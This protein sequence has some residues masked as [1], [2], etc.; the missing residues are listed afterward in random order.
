[1]VKLGNKHII[2][3]IVAIVVIADV[4]FTVFG[5]NTFAATA[6]NNTIKAD[7]IKDCSSTPWVVGMQLGFFKN[8]SINF[9]DVGSIS[10]QN[11]PAALAAGQINVFDGHPN[12]I[13]DLLQAGVKVNATV[14]GGSEPSVQNN[15]TIDEDHMHYDVLSTSPYQNISDIKTALANGTKIKVAV[16]ATGT[17]ADLEF[18]NWL[19]ENG[20][21]MSTINNQIQYVVLVDPDQVQAMKEGQIDISSLH[22]PFYKEAETEGGVNTLVTSYQAF[23][24]AA[25]MSLLV[26]TDQYIK[27]YPGTVRDFTNAYKDSERWI[28]NNREQAGNITAAYIGLPYTSNVHYYS[29]SGAFD[30]TSIGYLQDWINAM[31]QQGD[32]PAGKYT[33]QDLYTTEFQDTWQP[34]LPDN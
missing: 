18:N 14:V 24:P 28:Q 31:V 23:G 8:A 29:E 16:V 20:V 17:C 1:M 6:Q 26:F 3:S 5:T 32:I 30:N 21:N 33:P 9:I 10:E 34:N 25:G 15:S 13:I 19:L 22:P 4:I 27:N 2:A 11:E 12:T 7:V